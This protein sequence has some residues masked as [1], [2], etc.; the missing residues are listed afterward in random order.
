MDERKNIIRDLEVKNQADHKARNQLLEGLG[1]GMFQKIGDD[2]PF[3]EHT[4]NSPGGILAEY[5]R[6]QGEIA[7]SALAIKSLEA[8]ALKF[9]ELEDE[10]SAKEKEVSRFEKEL[11]EVHVRL[12]KALL[13]APA[14]DD[15]AGS[16]RLQEENLLAKI[17]EQENR[18][19]ALEKRE[20]SVLSW[21][22]KNAQMAVCR[23]ILLRSH[24]ALKRL[25]RDAGEKF[26]A[27]RLT[28][29]LD[30]NY[31]E[32]D[33]SEVAGKALEL[34]EQLSSLI[35]IL[36]GLRGERRKMGDTFGVEGSPARRIQAREKQIAHIKGELPG[37]HLRLGSLAAETG[38]REALSSFLREE[39]GLT[40][41]RAELLVSRIAERELE[42]KKVKAAIS[43]D[44][45]KAGIEKLKKA[46]LNQR[47]KITVAEE[48]IAGL[49]TQ[50]AKSEQYIDELKTFIQEDHGRKNEENS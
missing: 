23:T 32:N 29:S 35:A 37:V 47:Q 43:I 46:I 20:G 33:F 27:E 12:G 42:I 24:S 21:L 41:E 31:A 34:K 50:I 38:G 15:F 26:L 7:E 22:S 11:E 25:Y 39:D 16:M 4:K 6:L 44:E 45:E 28:E 36:A 1:E 40:L 49:E 8:D 9:K 10:I 13:E 2:E 18:L 48:A 30:G 17:D 19:D 5:R 14:F 3:L